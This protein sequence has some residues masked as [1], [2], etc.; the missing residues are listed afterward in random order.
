G[1]GVTWD[2]LRLG[3][4]GTFQRDNAAVALTVLALVRERFPCAPEAV[5][6]GLAAVRW[7]GR[8]AVL[9]ERPLVVVDGAH[10]PAG[11]A[12]LA[13]ELPGVV[14]D[15]RVLLVFAVM[16]DK[17]WRA[18]LA[19]LLEHAAGMIV[20]RVGR[21]AADPHALAGALRGRVPVLAVDDPRAALRAALART[22]TDGAVVVTGSLFLAGEAYAELGG[23]RAL[24][25]PF[26]LRGADAT[27]A[28]S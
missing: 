8:L 24:F 21:R 18:M 10:N 16:A 1:P 15:R 4:R 19:P 27:E 25:E 13:A 17:D 6:G 22:G 9:R 28:A 7:P 2:S 5:R 20:T 26:Q 14:G 23:P 11:A 12:T 3:L